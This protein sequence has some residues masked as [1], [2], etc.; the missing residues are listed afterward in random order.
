MRRRAAGM[1]PVREGQWERAAQP[2]L[3]WAKQG[4]Q[5]SPLQRCT[6]SWGALAL[7]PAQGAFSTE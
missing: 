5:L 3:L 2:R 7:V 6:G 1:S 4:S